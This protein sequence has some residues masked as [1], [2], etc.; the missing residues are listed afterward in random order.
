MP[1]SSGNK[2]CFKKVTKGSIQLSPTWMLCTP[3]KGLSVRLELAISLIITI[4][5]ILDPKKVASIAKE[6][7]WEFRPLRICFKT[8]LLNWARACFTLA[9]YP[10]SSHLGP[11]TPY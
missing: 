9:R 7:A 5:G 1:L 2:P 10:A 4:R 8:K 6:S 11:Q 3:A